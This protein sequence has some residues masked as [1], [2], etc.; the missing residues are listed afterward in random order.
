MSMTTGASVT[1][2]RAADFWRDVL[3]GLAFAGAALTVALLG[4]I[5]TTRG[6]E[7]FDELKHPSFT[8]PDATFGIVWTIL[9]VLIAV[10]GW[11]AS[12]ASRDPRPTIAWAVQMAL[13]LTWTVVFFGFRAPW[14][15]A[16]VIVALVIAVAIDLQLSARVRPL[17]GALLM[18]YLVWCGFA[19]ALNLGVAV[20]N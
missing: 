11:L 19:A 13:N 20:L 15:A 12:R 14:P 2:L 9:Y 18:P 5:A 3:A 16:V 4:N 17:A 10:A 8:P 7:W 6:E 1:R